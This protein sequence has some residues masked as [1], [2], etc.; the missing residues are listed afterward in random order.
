[1]PFDHGQE[2]PSHQPDEVAQVVVG[3][4][5]QLE[6]PKPGHGPKSKSEFEDGRDGVLFWK[7]E[8]LADDPI[9]DERYQ[10]RTKSNMGQVTVA[11]GSKDRNRATKPG[12]SI[13]S[14]PNVDRLPK[15]LVV[16]RGAQ[17]DKI[18]EEQFIGAQTERLAY[19]DHETI[20]AAQNPRKVDE[21]SAYQLKGARMS[22]KI[23]GKRT[24]HVHHQISS[25]GTL[26]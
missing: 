3:R 11:S 25:G 20:T 16:P 18:D 1:M 8:S 21:L 26:N 10:R 19:G 17:I 14:P 7:R 2:S 23:S 6:R 5:F 15:P 4:G 12:S 9:S 22:T 24:L 13:F